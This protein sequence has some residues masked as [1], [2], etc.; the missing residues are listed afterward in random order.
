MLWSLK[1]R[2]IRAS[3]KG[4]MCQSLLGLA[5]FSPPGFQRRS[6]QLRYNNL[7]PLKKLDP[8][9]W[10]PLLCFIFLRILNAIKNYSQQHLNCSFIH[11]GPLPPFPPF[12]LLYPSLSFVGFNVHFVVT[13]LSYQF[14]LC[15]LTLNKGLFL[16]TYL[17]RL[18]GQLLPS[19]IKYFWCQCRVNWHSCT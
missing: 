14:F 15:S 12:N 10:Q 4:Q 7:T 9:A 2:L 17:L 8:Y 6:I 19:G 5:H 18:Q 11:F 1:A 16:C 3:G 13:L